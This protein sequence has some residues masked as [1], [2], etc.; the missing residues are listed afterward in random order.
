[1]MRKH[2]LIIALVMSSTLLVAC[3]KR[4]P[5]ENEDI[6][7][8]ATFEFQV[9]KS[10]LTGKCYEAINRDGKYTSQRIFEVSCEFYKQK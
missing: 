4:S 9:I 8:D 7:G 6:H 3:G 5:P 1:M 10:P 2:V